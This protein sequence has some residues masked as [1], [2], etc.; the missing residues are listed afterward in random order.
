MSWGAS[1]DSSRGLH[2]LNAIDTFGLVNLNDTVP[3]REDLSGRSSNNLD[4]ILVS[5]DLAC[6]TDVEVTSD[7]FGSDHFLVRTL[8]DVTPKHVRSL[9]KRLKLS[10]VNWGEFSVQISTVAADLSME[11]NEGSDPIAIY[12]KLTD[13][14]NV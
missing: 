13:K 12:D 5:A 11:M 8:L 6:I 14:I 4:L 7:K 1:Y 9:N 3:T 10:K 2:I